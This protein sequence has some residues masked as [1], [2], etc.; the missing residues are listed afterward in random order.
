MTLADLGQ[1]RRAV[2]SAETTTILG[3]KGDQALVEE[4]VARLEF[5]AGKIRARK[6]GEGSSTGNQHDLEELEDR[7]RMLRGKTAVFKVGGGSEMEM[8]ERLVRVENA[9]KSMRAALEEGVLPGGGIGLLS[10]RKSLDFLEPDNADQQRGIGII[11]TALFEP[12]RRIAANAGRNPDAVEAQVLFKDDGVYGYDAITHSFGNLIEL[13]VVDPVKVTRLALKNAASIVGT[14]ITTDV[15]ISEL[16]T[17]HGMPNSKAIA[18][19]A[20]ATREDPRV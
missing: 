8:K 16:P 18:E 1:A 4:L 2:I 6:P 14:V 19:W 13:G 20:A 11:R 3:A 7:I 10:V 9:H 12:L 15:V 17:D 5:D